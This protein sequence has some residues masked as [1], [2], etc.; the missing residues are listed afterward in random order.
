MRRWEELRPQLDKHNVQIVTLCTD[1]P[2]QIRKG[3]GKHG[4]NA[5]M[6]SDADLSVTR[7]FGLENE[8][9]SVRP[10]GL[11]GLPIPTTIL[12]DAEGIVR[13]IDQSDDYMVRSDPDRVLAA[14]EQALS[15]RESDRRGFVGG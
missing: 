2:E 11:E 13:W 10:P 12:T 8:N 1:T 4:A 3:M 9:T 15:H 5:V 14:L 6:L 7:Q